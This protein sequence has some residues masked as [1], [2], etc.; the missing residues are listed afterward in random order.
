LISPSGED[1]SDVE[2]ER[3]R[4]SNLFNENSLKIYE[5]KEM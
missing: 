3:G 5:T 2:E 1:E 4:G